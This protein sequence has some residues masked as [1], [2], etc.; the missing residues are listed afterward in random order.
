MSSIVLR[1]AASLLSSEAL[2]RVVTFVVYLLVART[3]DVVAF[4]Q[5]SLALT[6]FYVAQVT[7]GFGVRTLVAREVA[8]EPRRAAGVLV[9]GS[10]VVLVASVA[11]V[12]LVAALVGAAGY[13]TDTAIVVTLLAAAAVPH[14]V[15][16]VADG[17]LHGFE[18]MHLIAAV[19]VPMQ[20]LRLAAVVAVLGAGHGLV[21]LVLTLVAA[22]VVSAL[23]QVAV[24]VRQVRSAGRLVMPSTQAVR[25]LARR[26]APFMGIDASI[27]VW[28]S[29]PIV[30]LSLM[31][32]ETEVGWF[33]AAAQL[34]VPVTLVLQSVTMAVYPI[35]ARRFG[36]DGDRAGGLGTV[37]AATLHALSLLAWP[38]AVGLIVVAPD[39]VRLVFGGTAFEASSVALRVM[40]VAIVFRAITS[41]LGQVLLAGMRERVTL[42]IV[43]LN[44]AVMLVAG[45]ALVPPLGVTGAAL[46]FVLAGIVNVVQHL[47]PTRSIIGDLGLLQAS[48]RAVLASVVMAAVLL[49]VGAPNVIVAI[50]LGV[51]VYAPIVFALYRLAPPPRPLAVARGRDEARRP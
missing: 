25:D 33:N 39:A 12:A 22:Q 43:V 26:A 47:A 30:L 27:A 4:G 40:A 36:A 35:M 29:L 10:L 16:S 17:I 8:R 31:R 11:T 1:N 41:A 42:R 24:A 23:L 38:A 2:H 44:G 9:E 21:P 7:G 20:V 15:G 28:S 50:G 46:A 13:A 19:Q 37:A 45:L 14:A 18:R 6:V 51:L 48:W 34:M 49:A 32:G 3:L 5:L